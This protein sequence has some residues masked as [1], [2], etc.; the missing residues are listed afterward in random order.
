MARYI[1][2]DIDGDNDAVA[3]RNV[4]G[5]LLDRIALAAARSRDRADAGDDKDEA[6]RCL[7]CSASIRSPNSQIY[8]HAA[9]PANL[10]HVLSAFRCCR[11][12]LTVIDCGSMA[13]LHKIG[14]IIKVARPRAY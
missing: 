1:E 7:D 3:G 10:P 11:L 2:R 13:N 6:Q 12:R 14:M 5:D 8:L 9:T 4:G